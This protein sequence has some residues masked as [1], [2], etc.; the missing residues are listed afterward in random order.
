MAVDATLWM[1]AGMTSEAKTAHDEA[2]P[3]D[4]H[5]AAAAAWEDWA[6]Q[7]E[8]AAASS[9][10]AE[11]E[12]VVQSVTTG[13]QS[14][15]FAP[16]KTLTSQALDRATWHRARARVYSVQVGPEHETFPT[17]IAEEDV[18]EVWVAEDSQEWG[19]LG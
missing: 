11:I 17:S 19:T 15:T 1:P 5:A 16:G 14:V 3:D 6:A 9:T 4:P 13:A 7:L 10:T 2:H 12:Q 18:N 8:A